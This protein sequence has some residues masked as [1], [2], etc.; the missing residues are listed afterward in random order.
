MKKI[1]NKNGITLLLTSILLLNVLPQIICAFT[2]YITNNFLSDSFILIINLITYL[3]SYFLFVLGLSKYFEYKNKDI[4]LK[5]LPIAIGYLLIIIIN[6][7][8][9]TNGINTLLFNIISLFINGII[10]SISLLISIFNIKNKKSNIIISLIIGIFIY[11]IPE[12]LIG[13]LSTIIIKNIFV[14]SILYG[15]L[16]SLLLWILLIIYIYFINEKLKNDYKNKIKDIILLIPTLILLVVLII[17]SL[18]NNNKVETIGNIIG[19]SLASG[20]NAFDEM[21]VLTSKS[22][23]EDALEFKCAYLYATDNSSNLSDCSGELLELFKTINK[24]EAIDIL[25]QKLNEK[26]ANMYDIEALMY[27]M[28]KSKDKDINKVT[29]YLISQMSFTR[30]S[31]LPFDLNDKEKENLKEVLTKYDKH[32][33][34]RKYIDVYVE[35]LK[36]GEINNN[37]INVATQ[38]ARENSEEVSLQAMALDFYVKTPA[39]LTGD[40]IVV[41]NFVN[42]TKDEALKRDD[43]DIITYKNY[44]TYAYKKCNSSSKAIKFLEEFKP[45]LIDKDLGAQLIVSYKKSNKYDKAE[46]MAL[47][48]LEID[49]YNV[50]ALSYL[51]VY[52]L[53]F[54]I[55]ESL[56][57]AKK[58]ADVIRNKKDNYLAAD[59]VL[60][61]Y[62]IYLTGYY[63]TPDYSFCPYHNF[64]NDMT[65]EQIQVIKDDDILYMY[66]IGRNLTEENLSYINNIIEKYDYMTYPYYYRAI[67]EMNNN[68][69]DKAVQDLEKAISLG[70][71]NPFFYSEL[72]FAYENVGNLQ[73]SLEAFEIANKKIDEYGLGSLT[74]NYNNIHNYFNV[75]I[76]NAKHAMYES[77]GDH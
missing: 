59:I 16:Y 62:R 70:N 65:D 75:Y 26:T 55:D 32:L 46:E 58:L 44:I 38:L 39:N 76:N 51:S 68:E 34:V 4:L 23:Y 40:S 1:F 18:P 22:F 73:K 28:K 37:V 33:L 60:G 57:Y 3:I 5:T 20:D 7:I 67:Y 74:Y 63:D 56:K 48:T 25:K 45:E 69:N 42:L 35:W 2:M 13:L 8:L 31:I 66:L 72:G 11:I 61:V 41:D 24:E 14:S 12:L 71:N 27:L 29:K 77:E 64:Y 19:Y 6:S 30:T 15:L 53:Q 47:K 54:D 21:E 50:E 49:E 9:N 17:I 10:F 43:K 36:Q 52:K